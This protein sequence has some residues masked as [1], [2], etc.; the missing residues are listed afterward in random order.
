[1]EHYT[2]ASTAQMPCH[3]WRGNAFVFC[4]LFAPM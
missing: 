4:I 3:W 2:E 1:M